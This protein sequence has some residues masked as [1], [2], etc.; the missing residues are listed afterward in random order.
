MSQGL[1]YFPIKDDRHSWLGPGPF[2]LSSFFEINKFS[3]Y[4]KATLYPWR[5]SHGRKSQPVEDIEQKYSRS[6]DFLV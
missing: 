5:Q 2:P 3:G 4:A 1:F 6:F